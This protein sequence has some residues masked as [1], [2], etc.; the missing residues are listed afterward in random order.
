MYNNDIPTEHRY[1][2]NIGTFKTEQSAVARQK[3]ASQYGLK[4]DII[5]TTD[6]PYC[7][8]T[9]ALMLIAEQLAELNRNIQQRQDTVSESQVLLTTVLKDEILRRR[10]ARGLSQAE[11]GAI[12][13]VTASA[14]CKIESGDSPGRPVLINK[15][16]DVLKI[17]R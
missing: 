1:I 10:K 13:G 7:N 9:A 17:K 16:C 6:D 2:V 5:D 8:M 14:I 4:A 15:I 12:C 3:A 11:L